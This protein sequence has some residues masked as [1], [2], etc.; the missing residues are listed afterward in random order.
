M[1]VASTREVREIEAAADRTGTSYEKMMLNAGA[2]ASRALQK[3]CAIDATT[4]IVFLIGKGNNGGDGLVMAHCLA[5]ATDADI[6]LYLLEPRS[7]T[8]AN[9]RAILD[10]GLSVAL[11]T[12]DGDRF[13][14]NNLL[15]DADIIVDAVLGIG[16]RLPLRGMAAD[17]LDAVGKCLSRR[18][19]AAARFDRDMPDEF[20]MRSCSRRPFVFA[21]DCPSGVDCD[22][23]EVDE[24]VIA[25][26]ATVTFITAKPGLF[27]FPAAAFVGEVEISQIGIPEAM[28]ELD[29]IAAEVVDGELAASFLPPRPLDGH[30]GTY[31]KAMVVAGSPNYIG[32]ITLAGEATYRA[33]AGLV[34]IAT[35]ANLTGIVAGSLREPTWLPLPHTDGAIVERACETIFDAAADYDS[36]L[37]GCGLGLRQSTGAFLQRLLASESLP[38]LILDAD[39]LNILSRVPYWW[40]QL[41]PDAIIT[42][43]AGEMARLTGKSA[44]DINANRWEIAREYSAAWNVVLLLKGA[45]SLIAAPDGRIS[46]I[47]IKT[48]ALSKAGTGDVLA[49]L[50]AGLRAQGLSAFDS[51]RLGA[52]VHA[53]AGII[54]AATVGSGRSVVAGDV[55]TAVG[56]AFAALE[57]P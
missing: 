42:P 11:A 31:G 7:P 34:T 4:R 53:S 48:D 29:A 1:K 52:Y 6:N 40:D 46:I 23:G 47:P 18:N 45:H 32:A 26:D 36:L 22:T 28:P 21:I 5:S 55:L 13:R 14:L 15:L 30:K 33:G 27:A 39:A 24:N 44:K 25:A 19:T 57:S 35:A 2:A 43:H 10:A 37:V 51:A 54:A 12:D 20:G 17:V 41:A 50:I 3:R 16:A 49:G 38:P 8:D 56:S 9:Y